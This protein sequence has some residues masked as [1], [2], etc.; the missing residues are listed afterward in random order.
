[1]NIPECLRGLQE[2][3]LGLQGSPVEVQILLS[4]SSRSPQLRHS[5]KII[6]GSGSLNILLKVEGAKEMGDSPCN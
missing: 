1:M 2:K 5:L 4:S 6:I 3:L